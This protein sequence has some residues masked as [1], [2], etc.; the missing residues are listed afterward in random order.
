MALNLEIE[1]KYVV[2]KPDLAVISAM[3]DYT[4]SE[5]CQIY[6]GAPKGVTHRARSRRYGARTEYTETV[7]VRI[8]GMSVHEMESE[9]SEEQF[10]VLSR[11]IAAGTRPIIKTRRTFT[12]G[13][14]TYEL[15]FY[16]EWQ[17]HC[18]METELS[19]RDQQVAIP[20]FISVVRE[21]TGMKQYTNASMSRDFPA[22]DLIY[23]TS[24]PQ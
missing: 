20:D 22:E 6:V 5:I 18:I 11:S 21:V 1:R 2:R 13:G 3:P 4:E 16:P 24:C 17:E 14:V 12:L 23:D 7:K 9:I 10:S 15:D 19:S 8:D